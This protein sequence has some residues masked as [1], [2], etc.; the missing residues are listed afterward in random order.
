MQLT[1]I[2]PLARYSAV[3]TDFPLLTEKASI[4]TP[5]TTT[6]FPGKWSIIVLSKY[7][8]GPDWNSGSS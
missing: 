6:F 1:T 3:I 5:T 8:H 7:P 4:F 2:Q